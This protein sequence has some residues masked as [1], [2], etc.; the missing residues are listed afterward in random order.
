MVGVRATGAWTG[1]T[2]RAYLNG[3]NHAGNHAMRDG[4]HYLTLK[5][6]VDTLS[7][8]YAVVEVAEGKL[9]VSGFGRELDRVL[10]LGD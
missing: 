4:V 3:H 5:G 1:T 10:V 2:T 7:T 9:V 6:M 8:S